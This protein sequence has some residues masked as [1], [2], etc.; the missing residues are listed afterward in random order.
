MPRKFPLPLPAQKAM[1]KL[2][3]DIRDA[4][5]RRRITTEILAERAGISR[6]TLAKVEKGDANVLMASYVSVLFSLGM[7]DRLQDIADASHDLTGRA[8][9]EERL[10]KRVRMPQIKDGDDD[11]E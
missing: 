2:G 5:L 11:V 1:R 8:L 6:I 3:Q 9:E 10:P 4:R 7:I